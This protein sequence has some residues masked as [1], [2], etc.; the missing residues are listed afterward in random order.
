VRTPDRT[1][2]VN[3][4]QK[5][6]DAAKTRIALVRAAVEKTNQVVFDAADD[7][8]NILAEDLALLANEAPLTVSDILARVRVRT[9]EIIGLE[10]QVAIDVSKTWASAANRESAEILDMPNAS[11]KPAPVRPRRTAKATA[12][13]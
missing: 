9:S 3:S 6:L 4:R 2:F 1:T 12:N 7:Y 8:L 10:K 11:A 13:A 5:R